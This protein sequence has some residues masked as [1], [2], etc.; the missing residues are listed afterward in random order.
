LA[1]LGWLSGPELEIAQLL[2]VERRPQN[3]P[4]GLPLSIIVAKVGV[5]LIALARPLM[6]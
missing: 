6:L 1:A 5:P 4:L 3:W 2:G